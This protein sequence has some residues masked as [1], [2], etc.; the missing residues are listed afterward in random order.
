M[1]LVR[2]KLESKGWDPVTAS[3]AT[4]W[5]SVLLNAGLESINFGKDFYGEFSKDLTKATNNAINFGWDP[6]TDKMS[7]I[8]TYNNYVTKIVN[9]GQKA[10]NSE[11]GG[12][13]I[14]YGQH[15]AD[16][17]HYGAVENM[18]G[19]VSPLLT[20]AINRVVYKKLDNITGNSG[21]ATSQIPAELRG[22]AEI[23]M[24]GDSL[25][26]LDSSGATLGII[27]RRAG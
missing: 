9:F 17:F 1:A 20:S 25:V 15:L 12:I 24:Q 19:F 10:A 2:N 5:A 23:K 18:M 27:K 22:A 16:S 11:N 21:I 13:D 7:D 3:N 26:Y 6:K 4:L 14:V 8:I